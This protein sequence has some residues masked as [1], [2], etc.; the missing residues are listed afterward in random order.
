MH[1]LT[2]LFSE[3]LRTIW[4]IYPALRNWFNKH[5]VVLPIHS[6]HGIILQFA[7]DIYE[8]FRSSASNQ[9]TS[10]SATQVDEKNSIINHPTDY[11]QSRARI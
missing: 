11:R 4:D 8:A 7:L 2:V 5:S 10:M 9:G 6:S 3:E 1:N